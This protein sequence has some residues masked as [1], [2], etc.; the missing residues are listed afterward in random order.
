MNNKK[1]AL[2]LTNEETDQAIDILVKGLS[3]YYKEK[4]S[5]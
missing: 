2:G 1:N 4:G 3:K 5:C